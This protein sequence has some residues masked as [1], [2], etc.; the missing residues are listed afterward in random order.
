[1]RYFFHA[2]TDKYRKRLKGAMIIVVV[3]LM[4]ICVFCVVNIVLNLR[5]GASQTLLRLLVGIICGCVLAGMI[6]GFAAVYVADKL[7]RRHSR[8]TFFDI[9][10]K[11]M[12]FSLYSGEYKLYGR[13]T[14]LRRLYYIPFSEVESVTR[15]PK[16]S[17]R[18]IT[19]KGGI[20]FYQLPSDRLG[21]HVDDN[22]ELVF[23]SFELNE[24]GFERLDTLEIRDRFAST[25]QLE[26]S[27]AYYLEQFRDLPEKKSFVLSE[28]IAL[29][30]KP[31][32][33]TSNPALDAPSYDRKW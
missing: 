10:P 3:P 9:L 11:G 32:P 5:E 15:N 8:Y 23:D 17:P 19:I 20:R 12:V 21:Y 7:T 26:K 13:R 6:F 31:R 22:D 18:S 2:D 16:I 28:H 29:R 1:M 4:A 30:S 24:R 33:Q 14:I 27:I 25:K